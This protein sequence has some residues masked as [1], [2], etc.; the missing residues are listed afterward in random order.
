MSSRIGLNRGE[1]QKY[2]HDVLSDCEKFQNANLIYDDKASFDDK[3]AFYVPNYT[4]TVE[5]DTI[6]DIMTALGSLFSLSADAQQRRLWIYAHAPNQSA[7]KII[8]HQ[9]E[10]L[11]FVLTSTVW[12]AKLCLFNTLVSAAMLLHSSY[13]LH[14]HWS[15][16]DQPWSTLVDRG[17]H[18]FQYLY[19]R[20]VL[21]SLTRSA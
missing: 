17:T 15:G 20:G 4:G 3:L 6:A 16:Y 7:A 10:T 2:I 18:L 9:K 13:L 8:W 11:L 5:S 12:S 21:V 14:Q 1:V 19:L